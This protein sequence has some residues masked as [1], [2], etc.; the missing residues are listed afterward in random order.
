MKTIS[1]SIFLFVSFLSCSLR[2]NAQDIWGMTRYGGD[3]RKGVIFKINEEGSSQEVV[4]SFEDSGTPEGRMVEY[5][6]GTFYGMTS[7]GGEFGY[8]TIYRYELESGKFVK[9]LDLNGE[10]SGKVTGIGRTGGLLL[11]QNEKLYGM[12]PN[13]GIHDMGILFEFNPESE[14]FLKLHDF[15]GDNSGSEP[16]GS[17]AETGDGSIFGMTSG[18]GENNAGVIFKFNPSIGELTKVVDFNGDSNG[19]KPLGS[20][21]FC[22]DGKLYGMTSL[23]G[24]YDNGVIFSFSPEDKQFSTL[25][26]FDGGE[27]GGYP[28]GSLLEANSGKL[29]GTTRNGGINDEGVL[30]EYDLSENL[31][32]KK[33]DFKWYEFHFYGILKQAS[34]GN[35]YLLKSYGDFGP[36]V[37]EFNPIQET[38]QDIDYYLGARGFNVSTNSLV[39]A[40]NGNLYFW[41]GEEDEEKD[42]LIFEFEPDENIIVKHF[43]RSSS[44]NGAFPHGNLVQAVNGKFYGQTSRSG[45]YDLGLIFEFNPIT[46]SYKKVID[47]DGAAKGAT[48]KGSLIAAGNHKLYGT[49]SRGGETDKGVL[50]EYDPVTESFTKLVDFNGEQKGEQPY[51]SLLQASNSNLYGMTAYGGLYNLGVVFEF[52]LETG[53]F[54]KLVD[55]DG[56]T[57]GKEPKGSLVEA[58]D[59][60]LY[61]CSG[62]LFKL[63]PSTGNFSVI[64]G[65]EANA[66]NLMMASNQKIYGTSLE[67]IE[68]DPVNNTFKQI[69][70]VLEG[71]KGK[72]FEVAENKLWGMNY[73]WIEP[74]GIF[75]YGSIFEIDLVTNNVNELLYFD[76]SNGTNPDNSGFTRYKEVSAP[77]ALC[78]NITLVLDESGEAVIEPSELDAGSTGTGIQ[79]SI[80]KTDF[81]CNDIGNSDITLTV[82]D[83]AG[84]SATCVAEVTIAD[85]LSPVVECQDIEV[86]LDESGTAEIDASAV[87]NGSYDACDIE[88]MTL[89]VNFFTPEAIGKNTVKLTVT[90]NSGNYSFCQAVVTVT[91]SIA[92]EVVVKDIEVF[93]DDEGMA[94]IEATDVDNGSDDACGIEAMTLDVTSFSCEHTGENMVQLTVSD[95]NGNSSV[96][97]AT[98]T[99]TDSIAPLISCVSGVSGYLEPY[100]VSFT[101]EESS[102]WNATASDNCVV[103]SLTYLVK[104]EDGNFTGTFLDE[105]AMKAG[106]YNIEWKALDETGNESSFLSVITIEKRPAALLFLEKETDME[107]E[108]VHLKALLIDELLVQ[109]IKGK[110]LIFS[111]GEY[112]CES[113]TNESGVASATLPLAELSAGAYNLTVSFEEDDTYTSGLL[114]SEII[115]GTDFSKTAKVR[116]YPNPFSETL[117]FEFVAQESANV[118]INLYDSSGKLVETIF[119][120]QVE[121]GMFYRVE[122]TPHGNPAGLYIYR[123]NNGSF[124]NSG[125]VVFSDIRAGHLP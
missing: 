75:N 85:T 1:L 105:Y 96:G 98:V 118:R 103:Q 124:L 87:D 52:D 29:Y 24:E 58:S 90:D 77:V 78:E 89:D 23:G 12:T 113:V 62:K 57:N 76:G 116:V 94:T 11:A 91:D 83:V 74:H 122:F 48:P 3:Y 56:T 64:T 97:F 101:A 18:G 34:N 80:S 4:Y 27:T 51:G 10:E 13:G 7:E 60:N 109:G 19:A 36:V 107:K 88:S 22:A 67:I 108:E 28:D 100:S 110:S 68:Y 14:V 92:P 120:E 8:G 35:I 38:V 82:S 32:K 47:F 55:F 16:F 39:E 66:N 9:L 41:G 30:F 44:Y 53:V 6:E 49:T 31:Y 121:A 86:F 111:L 5:E 93:L 102:E 81:T 26:E 117:F 33:Y 112:S 125:K 37:F 79:L 115:T 15:D 43:R 69:P 95:V 71:H 84:N 119:N 2:I 73:G 61:G 70:E 63:N 40:S 50:F 17:L 21:T 104:G 46:G 123:L 59:G 106:T 65:I 42:N 20:L 72:L 114:E 99:V 25:F 45:K 54:T